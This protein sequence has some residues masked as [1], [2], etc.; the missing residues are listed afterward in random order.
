M[1]LASIPSEVQRRAYITSSFFSGSLTHVYLH[2][3]D[4][5]AG[6]P[7]SSGDSTCLPSRLSPMLLAYIPSK[8]QR[9]AYLTSSFFSGSLTHVYLDCADAI[10]EPVKKPERAAYLIFSCSTA[11]GTRAYPHGPTDC[12]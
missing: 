6:R 4:A 11:V 12:C 5:I 7:L 10:T 3:A 1:L 9:S 8:T 2:W